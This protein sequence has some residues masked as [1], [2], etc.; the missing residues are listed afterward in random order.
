MLFARRKRLRKRIW[1]F[2]VA[3]GPER[4]KTLSGYRCWLMKMCGRRRREGDECKW[5]R[6]MI[7]TFILVLLFWEHRGDIDTEGWTKF[8]DPDFAVTLA[9]ACSHSTQTRAVKK[10]LDLVVCHR[11]WSCSYAQLSAFVDSCGALLVALKTGAVREDDPLVKEAR[12][13]EAL[14]LISVELLDS[15]WVVV[16]GDLV[17][18]VNHILSLSQGHQCRMTAECFLLLSQFFVLGDGDLRA[19]LHAHHRTIHAVCLFGKISMRYMLHLDHFFQSYKDAALA[20]MLIFVEL[21]RKASRIP[22]SV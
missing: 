12:T 14:G 2:D 15:S 21:L 7:Q 18:L 20:D 22:S 3:Y 17:L 8:Y 16:D 10:R 9:A 5:W 13:L 11:E 6:K 19:D 1:A 4:T